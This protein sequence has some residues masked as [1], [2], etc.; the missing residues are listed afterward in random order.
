LTSSETDNFPTKKFSFFITFIK[1][2]WKNQVKSGYETC[3]QGTALKKN[4]APQSFSKILDGC[5]F[6]NIQRSPQKTRRNFFY[7]G[8]LLNPSA[9][10]CN[11]NYF[12]KGTSQR[13]N[14]FET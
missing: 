3:E 2:E 11:P 9:A 6:K 12:F 7:E 10:F 4:R 13:I 14:K 8:D 5:L 1:A